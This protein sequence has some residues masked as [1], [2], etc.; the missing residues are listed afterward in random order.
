MSGHFVKD[1]LPLQG[2]L[3]LYYEKHSENIAASNLR[4]YGG[5]SLGTAKF[6]AERGRRVA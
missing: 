5:C 6:V 2:I 3:C 1:L 4:A